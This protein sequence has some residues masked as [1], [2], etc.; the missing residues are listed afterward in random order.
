[1]LFI[2]G[3]LGFLL[4][5]EQVSESHSRQEGTQYVKLTATKTC[6]E[7]LMSPQLLRFQHCLVNVHFASAITKSADI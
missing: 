3:T 7:I 5:S 1:M 4:T 2:M 6:L